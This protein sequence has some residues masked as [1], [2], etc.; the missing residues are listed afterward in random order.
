VA[1]PAQVFVRIPPRICTRIKAALRAENADRQ[2][3]GLEPVLLFGSPPS[4]SLPQWVLRAGEREAELTERDPIVARRPGREE[5]LTGPKINLNFA[6][7]PELAR[8]CLAA[9]AALNLALAAADKVCL[10]G[11][12]PSLPQWFLRATLRELQRQEGAPAAG[13]TAE[14]SRAD[15]VRD[16]LQAGPAT[17]QE[18]AERA[19]LDLRA[20]GNTISGLLSDG[21]IIVQGHRGLSRRGKPKS[22][23]YALAAESVARG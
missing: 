22:K 12:K 8:R 1:K 21:E 4:I 6:V 16:V 7:G 5:N 2:G 17:R 18:I 11:G 10:R 15:V 9:L 19:K 14:V 23:V 3:R 20:T 13:P